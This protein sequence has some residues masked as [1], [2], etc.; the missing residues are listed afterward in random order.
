MKGSYVF[1]I[2]EKTVSKNTALF[3]KYNLNENIGKEWISYLKS[4]KINYSIESKAHFFN[5][6]VWNSSLDV[7]Y[8]IN[9]IFATLIGVLLTYYSI[10]FA[11]EFVN[12]TVD[13]SN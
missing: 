2:F 4:W 12:T 9:W 10:S 7:K 11:D 1:K 8:W 6:E 13:Y 3:F 5:I